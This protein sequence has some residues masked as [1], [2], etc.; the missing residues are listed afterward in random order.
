MHDRFA[1]LGAEMLR[2]VLDLAARGPLPRSPQ[3][4]R[5][6]DPSRIAATATKPLDK[7]ALEI[8]WE[9]NAKRIVDHVRSLSPAP[10]ARAE[11]AGERVK[12]VRA[13]I[14][15][16]AKTSENPGMLL[17]AT[18]DA[19]LVAC[20]DGTVCVE[21]LVP[22]NRGPMDGAAFARAKVSA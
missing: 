21:R 14:G 11:L 3:A 7:D 2:E 18:G 12:I 1:A 19:A 15:E 8:D 5:G 16:A 13:S 4:T 22:P 6:V 20:G 10:G 9:W 17:G